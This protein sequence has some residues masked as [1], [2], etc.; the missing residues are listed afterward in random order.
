MKKLIFLLV[1]TSLFACSTD[2]NNDDV[3]EIT[4]I[5]TISN[6]STSID[7]NPTENQ[8]LGTI[9]ANTNQG[10]LS[11]S[12][13]DQSPNGA[14]SIDTSTGELFVANTTLF[15]FETNTT[16]SGTIQAT[17]GGITE[18]ATFTIQI[19]D[20]FEEN[21][22][23]GNVILLSQEG[24]N[25]FGA[26]QYTQIN[27]DLRIGASVAPN[28]TIVDLS[29]LNTIQT[30]S[31]LNI[32]ANQFLQ[33]L[34]GL[35]NLTSIHGSIL[36]IQN[37]NLEDI[38]SISAI[39]SELDNQIVITE[40]PNLLSLEGLN[41]ILSALNL[42][43][44]SNALLTNLNPLNNLTLIENQVAIRFND[45]LSD[46]CGI[47][48]AVLNSNIEPIDYFM[49]GNLFNPTLEDFEEGNCSL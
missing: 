2:S 14:I 43:I 20:I 12:I 5:I 33:N 10:T 32:V 24:V 30:A 16:I 38:T 39:N 48:N 34:S 6:F 26:N 28:F 36:I 31:N 41:N 29:P 37:P 23:E 17:N 27:G 9:N 3:P 13:T 35:E 1:I 4:T 25:D 19:N 45:N 8:S 18:M 40:N 15:D 21:I 42:V 22:F 11:F 46:L 44:E 47:Q 7:E 49:E